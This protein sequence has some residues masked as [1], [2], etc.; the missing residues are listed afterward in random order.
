MIKV[1]FKMNKPT[2]EGQSTTEMTAAQSGKP[3]RQQTKQLWECPI[4]KR[5]TISS[6]Y[7]DVKQLELLYA[8]GQL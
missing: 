8:A 4:L 6:V 1:T 3:K 5:L 7:E 2:K